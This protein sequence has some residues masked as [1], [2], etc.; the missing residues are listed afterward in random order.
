MSFAKEPTANL[1][2]YKS[3]VLPVINK[4][5]SDCHDSE[6]E[7]GGVNFE[8]MNPD[9]FT[10]QDGEHWEEVLNQINRG[11]MPPKKKKKQPGASEREIITSW[12][13]GEESSHW[14]N[15]PVNAS[16]GLPRGLKD[17]SLPPLPSPVSAPPDLP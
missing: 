9:L 2:Q 10:G 4:Y 7:E 5:C 6:N 1:S 16:D 8:K 17:A 3:K 11:D 12:L 14:P 15:A 13:Q